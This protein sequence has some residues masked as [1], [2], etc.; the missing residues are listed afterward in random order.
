EEPPYFQT[1]AM[2]SA[3]YA[4]RCRE[5]GEKVVAMLGLETIGYYTDRPGSQRYP[6][7]FGLFYPKTG[8]FVAFVG[9]TGSRALVHRAV[10]AFRAGAPFPSEGAAAPAALQGVGWSDHW[11]FWQ[12]GYPAVM[13]TDTAPF[14]N[15]DYHTPRDV[16]DRL[17]YAPMARVVAGLVR[18]VEALA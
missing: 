8:D 11:S 5:R 12:E 3:V 17:A 9:N 13:V 14:R 1:P 2:G 15:P 18:V 6:F 10:A 7:P 4:R 16:P